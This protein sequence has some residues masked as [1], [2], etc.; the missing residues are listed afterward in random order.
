MH[1][2][3]FATPPQAFDE[4]LPFDKFAIRV[5]ERDIPQLDDILRAVSPEQVS[6]MQRELACVY[7]VGCII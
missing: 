5:P 2:D 7:K 3:F 4:D 6:A 1:F